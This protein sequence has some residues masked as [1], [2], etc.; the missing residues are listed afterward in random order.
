MSLDDKL[1]DCSEIA[2]VNS[3]EG[4]YKGKDNPKNKYKMRSGTYTST[5]KMI[6][7]K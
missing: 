7:L 6:L 5:K 3:Y 2:S 1:K 4:N